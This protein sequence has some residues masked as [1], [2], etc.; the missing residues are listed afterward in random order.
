MAREA[1]LI[2]AAE[3][4]TASGIRSAVNNI[5]KMGSSIITMAKESKKAVEGISAV[6]QLGG[7]AIF[8]NQAAQAFGKITKEARESSAEF[9]AANKAFDEM[10]KNVGAAMVDALEPMVG[11]IAN[12]ASK[13]NEATEAQRK[14]KEALE[15]ST[16]GATI[17]DQVQGMIDL[18]KIKLD[19]AKAEM[20]LA[21]QQTGLNSLET[22][23]A[24]NPGK[25]DQALVRSFET[26]Q[27]H[28][29]TQS[30][31]AE[32]V[33]R[34]E[35]NIKGLQ[36]TLKTITPA[37]ATPAATGQGQGAGGPYG[38]DTGAS[39]DMHSPYATV[40][41][42]FGGATPLDG[43][44]TRHASFNNPAATYGSKSGSAVGAAAGAVASPITALMQPLMSAFGALGGMF[45]SLGSL[46]KVLNPL[47]TIF[48]G[49]ME[50]LGPLIEEALKPLIDILMLVGEILGKLL[51][52]AVK[53]IGWIIQKTVNFI[54]W[55]FNGVIDIL[56]AVLPKKWEIDHVKLG[57]D[58]SSSSSSSASGAG[59]SY[60]GAQNVTF[61][62]FNQGNVVGSGGLTELALIIDSI[63][64]QQARYA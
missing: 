18:E 48:E 37:S 52:P 9:Q 21:R 4:K 49:M 7:W 15:K 10:R 19:R 17:Q 2:I 38:V 42:P 31:W 44:D 32:A 24:M 54:L 29:D 26:A 63:L 5:D 25:S 61:N 35:N 46:S 53:A 50:V 47:Q 30:M 40:G 62:F 45:A 51:A 43:S 58:S 55:I 8:A 14:Y 23:G 60:A 12:L 64:K 22:Y 3:D 39:T 57:K 13:W 28:F 34:A 16:E 41:L 36:N 6:L 56:N 1:K 20:A 27:K 59:A 33:A 11:W